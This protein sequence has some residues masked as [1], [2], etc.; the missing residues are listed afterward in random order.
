MPR[1]RRCLR[2]CRHKKN[3]SAPPG[4]E[5]APEKKRLNRRVRRGFRPL[6]ANRQ[7]GR[8]TLLVE[9]DDLHHR[10]DAGFQVAFLF[11]YA[12][13]DLFEFVDAFFQRVARLVDALDG[14]EAPA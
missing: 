11:T 5:L 2:T 8:F 6:A 13:A 10:L 12:V 9:V 1:R 14:L 7:P 3:S 4:R